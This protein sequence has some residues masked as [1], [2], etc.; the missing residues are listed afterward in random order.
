VR[1]EFAERDAGHPSFPEAAPR[2]SGW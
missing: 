1:I 2:R